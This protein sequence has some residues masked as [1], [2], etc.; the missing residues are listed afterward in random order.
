MPRERPKKKARGAPEY[1]LTWGDMMA[2]L[3][4]FFVLVLSHSTINPERM[5]L[6]LSSFRGAIGV[7]EKGPSV[8]K[9]DLMSMGM[10]VS[11]LIKGVPTIT[12][13]TE[14]EVGRRRR[15]EDISKI[16]GVL[17]EEA[18][19]GGVRVRS[20]ERGII[21]QLT[22]NV[23]FDEGSAE[24][25]E[26]GKQILDRVIDLLERRTN[27]I[28]IEGHTDNTQPAKGARFSSNW[29]LAIARAT[30]VLQYF[31]DSHRIKSQRLSASGYG[32]YKPLYPNTTPQNR[33][34]NRR[35]DVVILREEIE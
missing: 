5:R 6:S 24:L 14:Y 17:R 16:Q 2:L 11:G 15:G 22:D 34:M 4:C 23:L 10:D 20:E 7:M 35:V 18:R 9:E 12:T 25:R 13:G 30:K 8:T 3:L 26:E 33:A 29:E 27:R 31:E 1:M 21:I 28:Q 19:K 32:E